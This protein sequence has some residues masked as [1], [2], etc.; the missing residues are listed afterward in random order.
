VNAPRLLGLAALVLGAAAPFAGSPYRPVQAPV[1]VRE[2]AE[3]VVRGEDR[4]EPLLLARW[5]RQREPGLRIFDLRSESDYSNYH[6]PGA[7]HLDITAIDRTRISAT[8]RV[9]TYSDSAAQSAQAWV[10]LRALGLQDVHFLR[11]GLAGWFDEV[12]NPVLPADA[13]IEARE[14]FES[15]AELSRYFGG[16]PR[17]GTASDVSA[18]KPDPPR[19][20]LRKAVIGARRRGC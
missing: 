20:D 14:G 7:E 9:V 6:I 2:L 3:A 1:D 12:I 15:I 8:D 10:F 19:E 17:I 13:S 18:R 5:I 16:V 11:S 4:I